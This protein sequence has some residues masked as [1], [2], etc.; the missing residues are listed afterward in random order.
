VYEYEADDAVLRE[1]ADIREYQYSLIRKAVSASG[2]SITNS[3]NHSILKNRITMMSRP[4]SVTLRG[5]RALYVVPLVAAGLACNSQTVTDY[6]V[7]E[8][9]AETKSVEQGNVVRVELKKDGAGDTHFY[10]NDVETGLDGLGEA[11]AASWKGDGFDTVNLKAD[12]DTPFGVIDDVRNVLRG[13]PALKVNYS[14]PGSAELSRRLPPSKE[15]AEAAGMPLIEDP[16]ATVSREN[17]CIVRINSADKILYSSLNGLVVARDGKPGLDK[18]TSDAVESIKHL[19]PKGIFSL[20]CDR[21]TSFGTFIEC[22]NALLAAFN[23]VR[24]EYSM[25]TFNKPMDALSDDEHASVL[26]SVPI[27]ISEAE[28]KNVPSR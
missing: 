6:K 9:P 12:P 17:I 22:Q 19:G 10:V 26:R 2:Y 20:Q 8:N 7:S 25:N 14:C 21:G 24:E 15:V 23:T 1:G 18:M 11:V 28:A 3:F 27:N 16:F 5:L 13:V 4:K